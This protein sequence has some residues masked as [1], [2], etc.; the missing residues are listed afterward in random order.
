MSEISPTDRPPLAVVPLYRIF[1]SSPGDVSEERNLARGLIK[2][3]LPY[4]P[5]F[6]GRV[7]F[8]VVAWDDPDVH[9]PMLATETPQESVSRARPRPATCQITVVILWSR[10]GTPLPDGIKKANGEP[11]ASGTEWE[12]EDA[13]NSTLKPKP[14]VLVYRRTED[15]KVSVKDPEKNKKEEQF[16]KVEKFFKQFVKPDGSLLGV[17]QYDTP[18]TFRDLLRK[19]LEEIMYREIEC[20]GPVR[21]SR[22][23]LQ[24]WTTYAETLLEFYEKPPSPAYCCAAASLYKRNQLPYQRADQCR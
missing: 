17:T 22:D 2:E 16:E 10:M 11:Y 1:L 8:E 7:S 23:G 13:C 5:A 9:I 14:K 4:L 21:P 18:T 24:V 12:Y 15:F 3:H 20:I 6:R 19:D